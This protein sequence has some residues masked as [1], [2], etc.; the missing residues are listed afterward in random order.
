MESREVGK[1]EINTNEC[2][3]HIEM[4]IYNA[5]LW[6]TLPKT[7]KGLM[8]LFKE[9][10]NCMDHVTKNDIII[11][12]R[13]GRIKWPAGINQDCD[14]H[15]RSMSEAAISYLERGD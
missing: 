4:M 5:M 14:S 8:R 11:Y 15:Q 1:A 9:T 7:C 12:F 6:G 3:K 2:I 10:S 13:E